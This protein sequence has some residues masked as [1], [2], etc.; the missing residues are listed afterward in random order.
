MGR[1][2]SARLLVFVLATLGL[3][4]LVCA[5]T[6]KPTGK[7]LGEQLEV[8]RLI[9][10]TD[11]NGETVKGRVAGVSENSF[12]VSGRTRKQPLEERHVSLDGPS[13]FSVKRDPTWNGTAIWAGV[14]GGVTA[15][16][17]YGSERTSGDCEDANP[18]TFCRDITVAMTL[19]GAGLGALIDWAR[20]RSELRVV[21]RPPTGQ[22]A[23]RFAPVVGRSRV[24]VALSMRFRPD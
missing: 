6:A 15:L 22:G 9:A 17:T 3:P 10:V 1:I 13:T 5:Q 8:G 21:L 20:D 23:F 7:S 14:F 16:M 18:P 11:A 4:S 2:V 19:V 12:V 24:G